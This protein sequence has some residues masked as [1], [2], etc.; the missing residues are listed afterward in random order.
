MVFW[1]SFATSQILIQSDGTNSEVR[2]F[3][4]TPA[5]NAKIFPKQLDCKTSWL[6]VTGSTY[7][8]LFVCFV[9]GFLWSRVKAEEPMQKRNQVSDFCARKATRS[10]LF[11]ESI[12]FTLETWPRSLCKWPY[13]TRHHI[14]V[15]FLR[16]FWAWAHL[17]SNKDLAAVAVSR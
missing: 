14:Q 7:V 15:Y 3:P 4:Q 16:W 2:F 13:W 8:L 11:L 12:G 17:C 6:N 1:A 5:L 10:P 9:L